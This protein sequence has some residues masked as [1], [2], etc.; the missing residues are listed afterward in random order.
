M[1]ELNHLMPIPLR[2]RLSK[3]E[4]SV[5]NNQLI[6]NLEEWIKITAPSGTGKTTLMNMLYGIRMDYD[7]AIILDGINIKNISVEQLASIHQSKMSVIF[8]DLRLFSNL[9]AYENINLKRVL[10]TP[11]YKAEKINYMAEMLGISNILSQ[12]AGICSYGE[13]QRIVII[14]AL[15]QPFSWLLMDEPFS[16][17]DNNNKA[18]A[19]KL[20]AQ[21]CK[22]RKAALIITDLDDDDLFTYSRK[23]VL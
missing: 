13:Q 7:G 10:Q 1:L 11:Y 16:H 12:K 19:A 5:W 2:D 8:Q 14:R 22:K 17:L 23:L 4:S 3:K 6:F 18:I 20:I 21:E 15:M 9:S